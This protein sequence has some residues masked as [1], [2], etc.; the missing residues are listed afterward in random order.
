M[1][2]GSMTAILMKQQPSPA[3]RQHSLNTFWCAPTP[4]EPAELEDF[5]IVLADE[6]R[7]VIARVL[8]LLGVSAP[9]SM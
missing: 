4:V 3:E 8:G 7:R 5:R 9:E 6:T 2:I 1:V